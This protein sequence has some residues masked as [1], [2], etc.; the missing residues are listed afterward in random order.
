MNYD[1]FDFNMNAK[2]VF[3]KSAIKAFLYLGR[4]NAMFDLYEQRQRIVWIGEIW[5][6][7]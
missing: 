7:A 4:D 2:R 1:L 5:L 6:W 3:N